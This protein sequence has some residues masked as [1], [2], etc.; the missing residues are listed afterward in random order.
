M[1]G[2]KYQD[3]EA[4]MDF[5]YYGEANVYQENLDNFLMISQE[6][7]LKGLSK[8][9]FTEVKEATPESTKEPTLPTQMNSPKKESSEFSQISSFSSENDLNQM[10]EE[11]TLPFPKQ[12][13]SEEIKEQDNKVNS[14]MVL[15][16]RLAKDGM[17]KSYI[18]QVCQKEGRRLNIKKHIEVR[19]LKCNLSPETFARKLPDQS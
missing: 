9:E 17:H 3:L 12:E 5:L 14:M 4:V 2:I 16:G 6:L 18:C 13:L 19:H 1:T 7:K 10:E 15:S 8:K 11:L